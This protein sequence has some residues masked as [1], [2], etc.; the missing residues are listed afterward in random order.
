MA[1]VLAPA[2]RVRLESID[3]L[4]GLVMILMVLDHTR[5]FVHRD[6]FSGD[7]TDLATTTPILFMTR[8][9]T[10]YC[11]PVFVFL[12]GMSAYL[13]TARG[14]PTRELS[15]FLLTRGLWLVLLELTV[16]RAGVWFSLDPGFLA[17][18]QVIWVLGISM[19]VLAGL[20]H[21]PLRVLAG[22]G[23]AMILLH[24]AF[25]AVRVTGWQGPGSPAPGALDKLWILLHQPGEFFPLIGDSGP[26]VFVLYPLI[27]WVGVLA[28]GYVC[29]SLYSLAPAR[30]R[31][32]LLRTG[33][34][35]IAAFVVLR[36]TNAYGDPR[37][38]A[39][40][41]TATLTMLSFVN[42]TKYPVSLLF[43]LMTLG[44]AL[45]ALA[46]FESRL[47]SQPERVVA[48]VGRVP[49]FFYLLQWPLAHGL[50]ILVGAAAGKDVGHLFMAPPAA[51]TAAS[52]NAGF[53]LPVV[54]LCWVVVLLVLIPACVWFAGVK[55][56]HAA[57]WLRY[58]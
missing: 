54:Y 35:L 19:V 13:Q 12:A 52:P 5:D 6:G 53:D 14:T 20:V 21:V 30:R 24:N 1:T 15:L 27:P 44:P 56:R 38:W 42:V 22:I 34:V 26:L 8:W 50:A 29:G 10:H 33:V 40:Q 36:A 47:L 37:P 46:W 58:L 39:M 31:L 28:V 48:R 18:L 45:L 49:M 25:D 3:L 57:S 4:R 2:P 41:S 17:G 43:L 16:V 55:Q 23:L 11:A 32:L 51:F 7:P 9:V